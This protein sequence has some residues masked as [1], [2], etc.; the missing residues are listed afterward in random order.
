MPQSTL[1]EN[2]VPLMEPQYWVIMCLFL[3]KISNSCL[4]NAVRILVWSLS[5][6]CDN[7]KQAKE[8]LASLMTGQSCTI[9]WLCPEPKKRGVL[10]FEL[11]RILLLHTVR[12]RISNYCPSVAQ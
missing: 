2:H 12:S 1:V 8:V 9:F 11:Y 6:T 3:A 5:E 7:V 10:M 4:C